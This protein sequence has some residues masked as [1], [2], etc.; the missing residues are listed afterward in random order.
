MSAA[1]VDGG[2]LPWRAAG[3]APGPLEGA[4]GGMA[5]A[6]AGR[7]VPCGAL[8]VGGGGSG[9][10]K[11]PPVSLVALTWGRPQTKLPV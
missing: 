5:G 7:G 4:E 10:G 11:K 1:D 2:A 3:G 8:L 9:M 6:G